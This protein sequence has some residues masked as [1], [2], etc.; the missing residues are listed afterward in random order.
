MDSTPPAPHPVIQTARYFLKIGE[1]V[2]R[3]AVLLSIVFALYL[4]AHLAPLAIRGEVGFRE[5]AE[6]LLLISMN[7]VSAAVITV[8]LDRWYVASRYKLL[9]FADLLAG[10]FTLVGAPLAG[11]LYI[12]GGLLIYVAAEMIS[13]FK[14]EEKLV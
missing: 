8:A 7:I 1:V 3:I 10:A 2:T 14:I 4:V 13:I 6:N 11:V 12:I 9:G 5:I